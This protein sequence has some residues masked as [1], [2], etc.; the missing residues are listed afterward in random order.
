M[1]TLKIT[2]TGLFFLTSTLAFSDVFTYKL[3]GFPKQERECFKQAQT[4]HETFETQTNIK[5]VDV[6]CSDETETG[7]DFNI[8]Y[9]AQNK[10]IFTTT[11]YLIAGVYPR[12]R[13]KDYK[14]CSEHLAGQIEL[15]KTA[16]HL[17]PVFNY[18][19]KEALSSYN[20]W[21]LIITAV[22]ESEMKPQLGG[23][24]LFTAP[25][26]ITFQEIFNG[27][28]TSLAAKGAILSDLVFQPRFPMSEASVHYFS[29]N[30]F[31]LSLDAVTKVPKLETC[32]AQLSEAKR[33]F[34]NWTQKPFSLFCGGPEFGEYELN[35]G[36]IDHPGFEF[37]TSVEKFPSYDECENNK[38]TVLEHYQGSTQKTLMGGLCSRNTENNRYHVIIF[39]QDKN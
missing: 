39:K 5:V 17:N 2:F 20:A 1:K 27:L 3:K 31:N 26:E 4:I 29:K 18:C 11:D 22:G 33:W 32:L 38:A 36:S 7:Y 16:T 28:K 13:Y 24:L 23:F 14:T 21:E 8:E 6:E 34:E 25:K 10:L 30:R 9:E 37:K 15:F 12:G 19:R 35:I